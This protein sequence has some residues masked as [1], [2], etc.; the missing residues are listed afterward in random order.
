L[1]IP[2]KALDYIRHTDPPLPFL[3]TKL[4]LHFSTPHHN[5]RYVALLPPQHSNSMMLSKH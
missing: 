1:S 5:T 3:P 2:A 4:L